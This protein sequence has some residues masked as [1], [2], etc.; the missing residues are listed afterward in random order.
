MHRR[1]GGQAVEAGTSGAPG[2]QDRAV[3]EQRRVVLAP[4]ERHRVGEPPRGWGRG[5]VEHLD[6]I[7]GLTVVLVVAA[8]DIDDLAHRIGDRRT[9]VALGHRAVAGRAPLSGSGGGQRPGLGELAGHHDPVLA[10]DVHPRIER[11][12]RAAWQR[13]SRRPGV[14]GPD[15]R[16]DVLD[17]VVAAIRLEAATQHQDA[18]V[19]QGHR[20]GIPAAVVHRRRR[21]PGVRDRVVQARLIDATAVGLVPAHHQQ[22]AVGQ[23]GVAGAEQVDVRAA[24]R[25][26]LVGQ[27][28]LASSGVE[29]ERLAL[30]YVEVRVP[31]DPPAPHQHPPGGQHGAVHRHVEQADQRSPAAELRGIADRELERL[32]PRGDLVIGGGGER[33]G[34]VQERGVVI[35]VRD[36]QVVLD[37]GSDPERGVDRRLVVLVVPARGV[38]DHRLLAPPGVRA[39]PKDHGAADLQLVTGVARLALILVTADDRH[40]RSGRERTGGVA[41]RPASTRL[42]GGRDMPGVSEVRHCWTLAGPPHGDHEDRLGEDHLY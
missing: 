7:G 18:A 41:H 37:G 12:R 9:V 2:D 1:A 24:R 36:P 11:E 42:G 16:H 31:G 39:A 38:E 15:L 10:G 22:P 29:Q 8:A 28:G 30:V 23:E 13:G 19:G 20:G 35:A 32:L 33:A 3:G 27:L 6:G 34:R 25:L 4:A 26:G 17:H 5:R 14:I 40:G 21:R